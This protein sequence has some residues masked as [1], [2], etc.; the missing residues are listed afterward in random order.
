MLLRM[1]SKGST[2][3]LLVRVKSCAATMKISVVIP[4]ENE[5]L[6]TSRSSYTTLRHTPKE[7]FILPQRHLLSH[8]HYCSIHNS[9]KMETTWMSLDKK[10][11]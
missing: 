2:P 6:S 1:W 8:V 4:Q 5:N 3:P 11:N 10:K 7:C 9:L